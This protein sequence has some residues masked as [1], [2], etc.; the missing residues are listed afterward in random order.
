MRYSIR[1]EF[2]IE[3]QP[4]SYSRG[5]KDADEAFKMYMFMKDFLSF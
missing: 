4:F 2:T 1:V 5:F 3:D